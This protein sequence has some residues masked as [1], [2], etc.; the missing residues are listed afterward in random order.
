MQ[1]EINQIFRLY[2]DV[3]RM[4][5]DKHLLIHFFKASNFVSRVETQQNHSE[6]SWSVSNIS[7]K[8]NIQ[9]DILLGIL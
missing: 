5:H 8:D 6:S 4:G 3:V 2:I 9:S 7:I 1:L